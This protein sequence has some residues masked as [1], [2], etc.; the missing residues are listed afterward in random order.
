MGSRALHRSKDD[1]G[2]PDGS[3]DASDDGGGSRT[4]SFRAS[5][6]L[7]RT[8][9]G[10]RAACGFVVDGCGGLVDCNGPDGE[11]PCEGA[12][13]CALDEDGVSRCQDTVPDS[14]SSLGGRGLWHRVW[15]AGERLLRGHRDCGTC[16]EG[17]FCSAGVCLSGTC[18]PARLLERGMGGTRHL[19][20]MGRRLRQHRRLLAA[21]ERRRGITGGQVCATHGAQAGQCVEPRRPRASSRQ[22]SLHR[23]LRRRGDGCSGTIDCNSAWP[24]SQC[25]RSGLRHQPRSAA[26]CA[27]VSDT[28]PRS[29]VACADKCGYVSNGAMASTFAHCMGRR[30]SAPETCGGDSVQGECGV[31]DTAACLA[32][33]QSMHRSRIRLR[34]GPQWMRGLDRLRDLRDGSE[35]RSIQSLRLQSDPHVRA[36]LG[37]TACAGNLD[38]FQTDAMGSIAAAAALRDRPAATLNPTSVGT[39]GSGYTPTTCANYMGGANCGSIVDDCSTR[40]ELL[41]GRI[42]QRMRHPLRICQGNPPRCSSEGARRLSGD[43]SSVPAHYEPGSLTRLTGRVTTPTVSSA[44]R[45]RSSS[46]ISGAA[47]PAISGCRL[48]P[49]LRSMRGRGRRARRGRRRGHHRLHGRVHHRRERPRQLPGGSWSRRASGGWTNHPERR[50]L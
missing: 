9:D 47:L 48:A 21:G 28:A 45:T 4:W 12:L 30:C 10:D 14:A 22:A 17:Q 25:R 19:Q 11:S 50:R 3:G 44:C 23:D 33:K 18:E 20:A 5:R 29:L 32:P 35:L 27:A 7:A 34:L 24:P 31:P 36:A 2:L 38:R 43:C 40:R 37:G 15:Q 1:G 39:G 46:Q 26:H 42:G 49:E 6:G 8:A 13:F 41:A 16:G